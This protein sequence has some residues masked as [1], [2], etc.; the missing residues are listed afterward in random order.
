MARS[1]G[2]F[3]RVESSWAGSGEA[4]RRRSRDRTLSLTMGVLRI[5]RTVGVNV[6]EPDGV[7]IVSFPARSFDVVL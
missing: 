7:R 3:T 5:A 4:R 2:D 1:I 6:G